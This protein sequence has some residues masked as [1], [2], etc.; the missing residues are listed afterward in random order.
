MPKLIKRAK[1]KLGMMPGTVVYVSEKRTA[2]VEI[3]IVGYDETNLHQTKVDNIE[4]V[5][6]WGGHF[7]LHSADCIAQSERGERAG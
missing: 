6:K 1:K 5:E 4:V 3:T 2:D 7:D